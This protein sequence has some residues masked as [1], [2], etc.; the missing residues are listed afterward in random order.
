MN[1]GLVS[2]RILWY[3]CG[4]S[5][6]SGSQSENDL[7][8]FRQHWLTRKGQLGDPILEA[9]L[10]DSTPEER[11]AMVWPLTVQAWAFKGVDIAQSRL[12]RHLMCLKRR[13][14]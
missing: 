12:P 9:S 2:D 4:M 1:S 14:G 6:N 7:R 13:A 3:Y 8:S 10:T 11:L 5:M